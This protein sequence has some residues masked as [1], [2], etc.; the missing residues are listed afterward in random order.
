MRDT[1]EHKQ[2]NDNCSFLITTS[3]KAKYSLNIA[4]FTPHSFVKIIY[5]DSNIIQLYL[6]HPPVTQT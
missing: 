3:I 1:R 6:Y 4:K 2:I 5:K